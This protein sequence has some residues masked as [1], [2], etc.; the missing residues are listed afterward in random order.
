MLEISR[1]DITDSKLMSYEPEVRFIKLPVT[2][3]LDLL[4]IT[5]IPSQVAL[6]NAINIQNIDLYVGLYHGDKEKT[7]SQIL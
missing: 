3:Y 6:I 5:P 4:G 7:I 1:K 2:G